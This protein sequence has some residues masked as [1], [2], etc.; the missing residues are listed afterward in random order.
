MNFEQ[1][2]CCDQKNVISQ[3]LQSLYNF[4]S[5]LEL[6]YALV[7]YTRCELSYTFPQQFRK[8]TDEVDVTLIGEY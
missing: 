5:T 2:G 1:N 7:R 8:S 6:E 4:I 3:I